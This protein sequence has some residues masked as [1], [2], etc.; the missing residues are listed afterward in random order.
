MITP[1]II[2]PKQTPAPAMFGRVL[3]KDDALDVRETL[4]GY[5]VLTARLDRPPKIHMATGPRGSVTIGVQI[6]FT[7]ERGSK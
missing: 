6:P 1:P 5:R 2:D 4:L 7:H 3:R